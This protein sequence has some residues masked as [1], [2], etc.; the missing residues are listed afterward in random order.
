MDKIGYGKDKRIMLNFSIKELCHSDTATVFKFSN[1]P[2]TIAVMD[3]LLNLIV[4]VLQ[5][6]RD[7]FGIIK[8]TSGYRNTRLNRLVGGSTTSNHLHGCAADIIP[9]KAT[10]K[11]VYDYITT[12]LDYDECYIET[13]KKSNKWLHLAYRKGN[14]RK[15][16]N[17]NYLA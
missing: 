14:N 2:E 17:Q 3:N 15:K 10:F 12:N 16:H 6:L 11:Q 8:V 7:E 9:T 4:Y 1:V 5:P 13:D